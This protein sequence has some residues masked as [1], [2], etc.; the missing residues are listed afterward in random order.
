MVRNE[1]KG[2]QCL[3]LCLEVSDEAGIQPSDSARDQRCCAIAN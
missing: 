2:K 3:D 1:F